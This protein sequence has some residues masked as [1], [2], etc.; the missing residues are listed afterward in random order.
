MREFFAYLAAIGHDWV[1]L[2]TGIASLFLWVLLAASGIT[3]P[4]IWSL[5]TLGMI[6]LLIA[7]FR[8]WRDQYRAAEPIRLKAETRDKLAGLLS[9]GRMLRDRC[10]EVSPPRAERGAA[11]AAF[12]VQRASFSRSGPAQMRPEHEA[13]RLLPTP[14]APRE[15]KFG[16]GGEKVPGVQP[17]RGRG[18]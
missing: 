9:Q 10:M 3:I 2:M 6:C 5:T 4:A 1:V 15:D 11:S 18:R 12:A 16:H 8:T 13:D 17:G 14:S 7:G